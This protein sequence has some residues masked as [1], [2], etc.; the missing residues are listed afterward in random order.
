MAAPKN[1]EMEQL[2]TPL[3]V[4]KPFDGMYNE[5]LPKAIVSPM[6]HVAEAT[7]TS[8]SK[9]SVVSAQTCSNVIRRVTRGFKC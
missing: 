8:T 5:D 7:T 1:G 4:P 6:V 9:T 3:R 2:I